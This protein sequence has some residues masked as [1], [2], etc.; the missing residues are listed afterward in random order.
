MD[1]DEYSDETLENWHGQISLPYNYTTQDPR[2]VI[3][4]YANSFLGDAIFFLR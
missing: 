1:M 2:P 3:G 4:L